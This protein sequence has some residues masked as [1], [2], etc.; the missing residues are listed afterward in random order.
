MLYLSIIL[1]AVAAA[2]GLAILVKWLTNKDASKAVIYAHGIGA[3]VAFLL[4]IVFAVRNPTGYPKISIILF[5]VAAV[6]GLYMFIRD[7]YKKSS[8][9][10]LAIAHGLLAVGGFIALLFFVFI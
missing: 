7:L 6:G 3:V 5:A 1:F 4:L 2:L 8:P 10:S 9:M